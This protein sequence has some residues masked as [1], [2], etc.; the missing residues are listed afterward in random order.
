MV[1]KINIRFD[2]EK[3][4]L[5]KIIRTNKD[6][7]RFKVEKARKE[8]KFYS[9]GLEFLSVN[10][11]A[12]GIVYSGGYDSNCMILRA[13]KEGKIVRPIM[14]N[15]ADDNNTRIINLGILNK[16]FPRQILNPFWVD[17]NIMTVPDGCSEGYGM[18]QQP[19]IHFW[20]GW[21]PDEIYEQLTEIQIGYIV[22]DLGGFF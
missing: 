6:F 13:L 16:Q 15:F 14:F 4:A 22:G 17:K 5:T 1:D 7:N 2:N 3:A 8:I 12:V 18:G 10:K 21:L 20:L 9:A 19:V 11:P